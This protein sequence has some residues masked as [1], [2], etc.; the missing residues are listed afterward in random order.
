MGGWHP[1]GDS[2]RWLS[3]LALVWPFLS[4]F[5]HFHCLLKVR[6]KLCRELYECNLYVQ[7]TVESLQQLVTQ[8]SDTGIYGEGRSIAQQAS[9]SSG[10]VA[11]VLP[12]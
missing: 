8:R 7:Q 12:V 1:E 11:T 4:F 5:T 6:S 9:S 2:A 3:W 10:R